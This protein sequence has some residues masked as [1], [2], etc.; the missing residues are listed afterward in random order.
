MEKDNVS[1]DVTFRRVSETTVAV[2]KQEVLHVLGV[3]L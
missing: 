3:C 2:Q 1:I